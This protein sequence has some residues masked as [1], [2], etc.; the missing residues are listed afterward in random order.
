MDIKDVQ[1]GRKDGGKQ[2]QGQSQWQP[3]TAA[4]GQAASTALPQGQAAGSG[5]VALAGAAKGDTKPA[6]QPA[7]NGGGD[8]GAVQ[9]QVKPVE[10]NVPPRTLAELDDMV[11]KGRKPKLSNM[12]M[13]KLLN[14]DPTPTAEQ[15]ERERKKERR[16][17][18]FAALGEGISALSNLYFTSQYAPNAYKYDPTTSMTAR[19]KARWERLRAERDAN[20]RAYNEGVLRAQAADEAAAEKER[21]WA[22]KLAL[23]AIDEDRKAKQAE[24]DTKLKEG[25]ISINQ[26]KAKQEKVNA[27]HAEEKAKLDAEEQ[28]ARIGNQKAQAWAAKARG[29]AYDR[30]NRG[31]SGGGG[32]NGGGKY[33]LLGKTYGSQSEYEKAVNREAKKRGISLRNE[34]TEGYMPKSERKSIAQLAAEVEENE[35]K[36]ANT[37]KSGF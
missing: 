33:T 24:L 10:M 27:D 7:A 37:R 25:E 8:G 20:L 35:A 2:G 16:E 34:Y 13:Y 6:A 5:T 18:I 19:T 4:K 3:Q 26:Y 12:E 36:Y 22:Y 29:R 14:P 9:P 21:A 23:N 30:S 28:R 15:L 11:S 1:D 17:K 32:G 31:G